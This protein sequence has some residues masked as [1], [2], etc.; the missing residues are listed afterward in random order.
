MKVDIYSREG[1][2]NLINN[3]FPAKTAVISFY[4]PE[5]TPVDYKGKCAALF[6]ICVPDT[7]FESL[8]EEG[9]T[10]ETFFPEA[11]ELVEFIFSFTEK[12][13]NFICQCEYG[14]SRSAGCAAAIKEYFDFEGIKI[15][16]DYRYCPSQLIYNKVYE[17]LMK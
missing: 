8:E 17:A 13:F 12:G 6:Q 16:A 4:D 1:I 11:D 9:F 3:G 10:Y 5:D 14:Q 2:E 7:D 15:F